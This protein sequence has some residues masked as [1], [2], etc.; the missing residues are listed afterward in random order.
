MT[1]PLSHLEKYCK[2]AFLSPFSCRFIISRYFLRILLHSRGNAFWLLEE[3]YSELASHGELFGVYQ[4]TISSI[5]MKKYFTVIISTERNFAMGLHCGETNPFEFFLK[6]F[7]DYR[8][9][10]QRRQLQK[11]TC[12]LL[13][14]ANND[15]F[16]NCHANSE[17]QFLI[18]E[19][20]P[21]ERKC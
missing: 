8:L 2:G 19:K 6:L 17:T 5:L 21:M 15:K 13:T 3:V 1:P 11:E 7:A 12:W 18:R 20:M 4:G 16:S 10:Y 9:S 14:A